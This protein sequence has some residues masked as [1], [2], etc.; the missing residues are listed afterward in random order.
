LSTGSTR[1]KNT[2]DISFCGSLRSEIVRR[3]IENGKFCDVFFVYSLFVTNFA[4]VV[5]FLIDSLRFSNFLFFLSLS[6]C[7]K[8]S[9]FVGLLLIRWVEVCPFGMYRAAI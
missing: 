8:Y 9:D 6:S 7:V 4:A 5:N 1:R 2:H 3:L